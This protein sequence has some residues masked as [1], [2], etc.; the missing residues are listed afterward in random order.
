[1][2]LRNG[3]WL[4]LGVVESVILL[5]GYCDHDLC[6]QFLQNL[7]GRISPTLFGIGVPIFGM[8]IH[9][10]VAVFHIL[11]QDHGDLDTWPQF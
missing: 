5:A 7:V 3:L 10:G 8:C 6:H 1:M 9:F 2:S 11:F 4:H